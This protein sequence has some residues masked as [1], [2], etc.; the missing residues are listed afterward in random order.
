MG[1]GQGVRGGSTYVSLDPTVIVSQIGTSFFV[2]NFSVVLTS[3]V[4]RQSH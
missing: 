2:E 3:S 1:R 4:K